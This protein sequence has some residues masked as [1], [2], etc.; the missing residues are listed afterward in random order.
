M[1]QIGP[2]HRLLY[3]THP[4]F[5]FFD[6]RMDLPDQIMFGARQL[7]DAACLLAKL[8]QQSLLFG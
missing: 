3:V 6:L 5:D 1:Q 4:F 2:I 8:P 7:F